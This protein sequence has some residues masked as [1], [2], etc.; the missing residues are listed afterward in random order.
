LHAVFPAVLKTVA[1]FNKKDPIVIGVDVV[2]GN[3]K[4]LTPIAA[5]KP[6]PTTGQKVI[7][8]LGRV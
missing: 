5:V 6:N 3:L 1:V 8:Q 4:L 7:I 2:E